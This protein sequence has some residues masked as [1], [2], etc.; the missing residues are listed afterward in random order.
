MFARHQVIREPANPGASGARV[1]DDAVVDARDGAKDVA[2]E[3]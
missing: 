1:A 2:L 3:W